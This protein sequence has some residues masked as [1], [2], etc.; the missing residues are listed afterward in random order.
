[1]ISIRDN[2]K[3][4]TIIARDIIRNDISLKM[5]STVDQRT[6]IIYLCLYELIMEL[7]DNSELFCYSMIFYFFLLYLF[8]YEFHLLTI[9]I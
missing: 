8:Y 7:E 4:H 9:F 2:I 5:N 6:K 3:G 1:M